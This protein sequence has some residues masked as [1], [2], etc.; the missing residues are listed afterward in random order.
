MTNANNEARV[1]GLSIG[2]FHEV[3]GGPRISRNFNVG[4]RFMKGPVLH[5]EMK[6]HNDGS[7]TLVNLP[8][9]LEVL[10]HMV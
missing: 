9:G 8:H 1:T 6:E 7:W 10:P 5:G 2:G 3:V 4:W